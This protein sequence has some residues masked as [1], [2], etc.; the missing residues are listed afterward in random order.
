ME[1]K[2]NMA[3]ATDGPGRPRKLFDRDITKDRKV[4][5]F[6][7]DRCAEEQPDIFGYWSDLKPKAKK[8]LDNVLLEL[9][10]EVGKKFVHYKDVLDGGVDSKGNKKTPTDT[11]VNN[12]ISTDEDIIAF[13]KTV[14]LEQEFLGLIESAIKTMD[15]RRSSIKILESLNHD[16]YYE[17]QGKAG[18]E[19]NARESKKEK[20][21]DAK[22]QIGKGLAKLDIPDEEEIVETE[23]TSETDLVEEIEQE[24]DVS[25]DSPEETETGEE[26]MTEQNSD[27][28]KEETEDSPEEDGTPDEPEE[29]EETASSKKDDGPKCPYGFKIGVDFGMKE[30]CDNDCDME[31][32][33]FRESKKL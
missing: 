3:K 6:H 9:E 19:F 25:V 32:V 18:D 15:Q 10:I 29:I 13:K 4:S 21:K 33:C 27:V 11:L 17:A 22:T 12:A 30:D 7:L 1:A 28:P 14:I 24:E 31:G 16:N 5:K 20:I 2:V 8:K 23:D 26:E